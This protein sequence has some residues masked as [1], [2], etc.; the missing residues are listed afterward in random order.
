VI[1]LKLKIALFAI[2]TLCF[3]SSLWAQTVAA[4]YA[5]IEESSNFL[6]FSNDSS[7]FSKLFNKIDS[8]KKENRAN[9][10][11]VHIGGSHVQGGLWSNTFISRLQN[12]HLTVGGGF[13]AFPYKMAKTNGQPYISSYTN[14]SWKR[15]RAVTKEFCLPL[16]MNGISISTNDSINYFGFSLTDKAICRKGNIIKVYHNF[17]ASFE[18]HPNI[19]DSC[20]FNREEFRDLGYSL[21]R[22]NNAIDSLS[23]NLIRKDTLTKDFVLFG[24][25]IENTDSAGFY[26]AGLGLNGAASNTFLRCSNIEP[27]LQSLHADLYILS[28]GVNDVQAVDFDKNIFIANYDSLIQ[29]LKKASPDAAILL[30]TTTDN[31]IRKKIPNKRT[32]IAREAMFELMHKHNAAVWD[33]YT[34]MGGYRSMTQWNLAGL[35]SKDK[36][37][38]TNRGYVLVGDLMFD[39]FQKAYMQFQKQ[40]TQ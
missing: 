8:I 33:T 25:S 31:Y 32:G 36:V 21:F 4:K 34:L 28:L 23:F 22:F 12:A 10:N 7:S 18:F 38:F 26:F 39:A 3:A 19:K 35:A 24:F 15:C 11:I 2:V 27:Q 40:T 37:H 30:T 29:I 14:G 20:N 17:N 16:G 1:K 6:H 5:F 13:F 9:V